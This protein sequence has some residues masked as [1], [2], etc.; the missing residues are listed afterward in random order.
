MCF[1]F[2]FITQQMDPSEDDPGPVTP[3]SLVTG[4]LTKAVLVCIYK[5][6]TETCK[7][8]FHICDASQLLENCYSEFPHPVQL[9]WFSEI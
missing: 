3:G 8:I 2:I 6:N 4:Q 1:L 7:K 9:E 5:D